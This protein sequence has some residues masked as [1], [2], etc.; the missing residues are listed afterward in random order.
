M[1]QKVTSR[2]EILSVSRELVKKE[3]SQAI[4]IRSVAKACGV[5]VGSI[6]NYFGSKTNLLADTVESIWN[7]IFHNSDD[8]D[9]YKDTEACVTWMYRRMEAGSRE[10]PGFVA[11]HSLGL[12]EQGKKENIRRMNETQKHI[13]AG[14]VRVLKHDSR[15]RKDAF[16]EAFTPEVFGNVL[17]SLMLTALLREDYDPAPVL[18]VLRR[19]IY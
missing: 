5:S 8:Q 1:N 13:Q 2:E 10:Y 17:F 6:Y 18:E 4:S 15:V 12:A 14:L 19:T 16:N 3:G 7:V 11:L 9:M